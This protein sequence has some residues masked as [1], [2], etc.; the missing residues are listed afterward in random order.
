MPRRN[1]VDQ[2]KIAAWVRAKAK[3]AYQRPIIT[4]GLAEFVHPR[5]K[6]APTAAAEKAPEQWG[7]IDHR[8]IRVWTE[9]EMAMLMRAGGHVDHLAEWATQHP[10]ETGGV[11]EALIARRERNPE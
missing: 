11:Y 2:R 8:G 9:S 3:V 10:P 7:R 6:I 1:G 4:K 5:I